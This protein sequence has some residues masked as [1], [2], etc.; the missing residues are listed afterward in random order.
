MLIDR[1]VF[2]D[3][4]SVTKLTTM[5]LDPVYDFGASER[6]GEVYP[7]DF[8][9]GC[10]GETT[11]TGDPVLDIIL[12]SADDPGFTENKQ[13]F[14]MFKDVPKSRLGED[15]GPLVQRLPFGMG[16]YV[17]LKLDAS[18]EFAC[19]T[20]SA[21]IALNAQQSRNRVPM[22][23]SMTNWCPTIKAD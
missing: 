11:A 19:T 14:I 21:G 17:R 6:A 5:T 12:E 15:A 18:G 2:A 1:F 7:F 9:F 8:F 3:K 23:E 20:F 13:E 16:R 22:H 10:D 4:K